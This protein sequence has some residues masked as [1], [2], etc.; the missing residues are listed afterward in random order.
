LRKIAGPNVE[1]LGWQPDSRL[2]DLYRS[3]KALVFPG[4][5]DFGIVPVEAMACGKPVI[6][7]RGGGALETVIQGRTGVYFDRRTPESL[8]AAVEEFE[9]KNWNGGDIRE[10]ALQ[11]SK[12][13][14]VSQIKNYLRFVCLLPLDGGGQGGGEKCALP[15]SP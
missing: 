2:L 6:A 5:E 9:L 14:F 1:F 15:P 11:F 13:S 4:V 8:L 7:Y 10:H 3:C 12:E